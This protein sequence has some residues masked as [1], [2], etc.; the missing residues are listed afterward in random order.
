MQDFVLTVEKNYKI[1]SERLALVI[2]LKE[3]REL[4]PELKSCICLGSVHYF[5]RHVKKYYV[6]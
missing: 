4:T 2:F 1:N 3:S 6:S 5:V